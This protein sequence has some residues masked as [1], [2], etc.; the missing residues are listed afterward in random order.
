MTWRAG[1]EATP[2]FY[3]AASVQLNNTFAVVGGFDETAIHL[4]DQV[5]YEWVELP[6]KLR[7]ERT[8]PA[9]IA[10]S[11]NLGINC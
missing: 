10:L 6:Q 3:Q 5:H 1:P 2:F 7:A 11:K 9:A 4:F 8:A